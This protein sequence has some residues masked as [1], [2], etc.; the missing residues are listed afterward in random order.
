MASL[1]LAQ[2]RSSYS[3][4]SFL[5]VRKNSNPL[6][7]LK[8]WLIEAQKKVSID[9]NAMNLATIDKQGNPRSRYVLLKKLT[10][11]GLIFFTQHQGAKS[12]E[13]RSCKKVALTFYWRELAKQV[14]IEGVVKKT[15]RN[16][17]H[18]YFKKRPR[19]SQLAAHIPKQSHPLTSRQ[20][21]LETYEELERKYQKTPLSCPKTW[22]GYEV[23]IKRI[24]FWQGA[25]HRL[26]HRV[27][28]SLKN[29]R[30][31]NQLLYP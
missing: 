23:V 26:H 2:Q 12:S 20:K 31:S 16:T 7:I 1:S 30:W 21:L 24:E 10:S 22:G 9:A 17:D 27:S 15:S 11:R 28:F 5:K 4:S 19:A 29:N 3:Q 25:P 6:P 18:N 8:K 13:L 14:R